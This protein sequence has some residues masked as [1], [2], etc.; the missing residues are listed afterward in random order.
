MNKYCIGKELYNCSREKNMLPDILN[1]TSTDNL[2][3]SNKKTKK[4]TYMVI[5]INLEQTKHTKL[6]E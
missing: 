6:F 3:P 4:K 5:I 2:P 1:Q